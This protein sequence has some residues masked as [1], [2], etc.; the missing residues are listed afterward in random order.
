[1]SF[2]KRIGDVFQKFT[3]K[4]VEKKDDAVIA[5][6]R[7]K[8]MI[9][10]CRTKTEEAKATEND[11]TKKE[12]KFTFEQQTT[13][14]TTK[15]EPN[16]TIQ[17]TVRDKQLDEVVAKLGAQFI[18]GGAPSGDLYQQLNSLVDKS[19]ETTENNVN[20][21]QM[22]PKVTINPPQSQ[23]NDKNKEIKEEKENKQNFGE[24]E[25]KKEEILLNFGIK[26]ENKKEEELKQQNIEKIEEIKE[27]VKVEL[28]INFDTLKTTIKEDLPEEKLSIVI[29]NNQNDQNNQNTQINEK[30]KDLMVDNSTI[31]QKIVENTQKV[32]QITPV[33]EE[34]TS[35]ETE[36]LSI[37]L[38]VINN[39]EN[40]IPKPSDHLPI[41]STFNIEKIEPKVETITTID[42]NV[43]PK[44]KQSIDKSKDSKL[45]QM[46][47][48]NINQTPV[49]IS[50]KKN[51]TEDK[52]KKYK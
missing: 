20:S 47:N 12:T 34:L 33:K 1:M 40:E 36:P 52:T 26:Q 49:V 51:N 41:K 18:R 30:E 4:N 50:N 38:N 23:I 17:P 14:N 46:N 27:N 16:V 3:K 37:Q 44:E 6:D 45:E 19:K 2:L 11:Y 43:K 35:K 21:P 48:I 5:K 42:Q 15:V 31:D 13:I 25:E 9:N 24:K 28:P 39:K 32:E 7:I 29:E 10:D 8:W 22:A